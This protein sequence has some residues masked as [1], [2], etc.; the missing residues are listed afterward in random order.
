MGRKELPESSVT[1][2]DEGVFFCSRLSECRKDTAL[3]YCAKTH[4]K[5]KQKPKRKPNENQTKTKRKSK[6]KSKQK[7]YNCDEKRIDRL[8]FI[9]MIKIRKMPLTEPM[10]TYMSPQAISTA[11][12][13]GAFKNVFRQFLTVLPCPKQ[14]FH[15]SA[16][17]AY[18]SFPHPLRQGKILHAILIRYS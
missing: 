14:Y 15:Y 11:V 10:P 2:E 12:S 7:S 4:A 5:T 17:M 6:Q 9:S 18:H 16:F 13:D 3:K 8:I 1:A